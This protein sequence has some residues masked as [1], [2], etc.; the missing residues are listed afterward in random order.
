MS[1]VDFKVHEKL[2]KGAYSNVYKVTRKEDG[3]VY[4]M[5]KVP[6][7]DLSEKEKENA[8]NEVRLLASI[9]NKHVVSYKQAFW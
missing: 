9:E 2:G 5:K 3:Q 1:I 4:A 7:Q 6:M 8:L